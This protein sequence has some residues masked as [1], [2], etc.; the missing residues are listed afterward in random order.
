VVSVPS[1]VRWIAAPVMSGRQRAQRV[2]G[3]G[4]RVGDV[5]VAR[6]ARP[7]RRKAAEASRRDDGGGRLGD[8]IE[9]AADGS[10]VAVDRTVGVLEEALLG[11]PVPVDDE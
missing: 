8:D 4:A 3:P 10:V 1:I 7:E 2:D 5:A 11:V 9:D 6:H